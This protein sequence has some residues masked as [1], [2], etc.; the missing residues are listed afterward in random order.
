[1]SAQTTIPIVVVTDEHYVILLGVLLKSIEAN[2]KTGEKIHVY[3]IGDGVGKE[4]QRKL[5][6]SVSKDMFTITWSKMDDIIPA[7]VTLPLDHTSFPLTTYLRLFIPNV[8]PPGTK[9]ALFLDVDMLVLEDI[10]KLWNQDTGDY[11]IAAVQDPRLL[12]VDNEWGGIANYKELNLKPKTKYF[13]A[14][15]LVV[16]IPQWTEQNLTQ[17]ILDCVNDNIKFANYPDQYGLNVVLANQWYELDHRWNYFASETL[18]DPFLIHFVSRKPIYTTYTNNPYYKEL[19]EKYRLQ[20]E[21]KNFKPIGEL[22]RY[23]KKID[24]IWVKVKKLLRIS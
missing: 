24:N 11:V 9:K 13:N 4:S 8:V 1:M 23:V 14:G 18:K 2:H 20:T 7:G 15:L 10:S 21:W 22:N 3:A 17:R 6:D 16:N 5:A 19:F 12:T